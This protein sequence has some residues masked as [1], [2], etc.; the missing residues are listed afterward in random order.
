MIHRQF[1]TDDNRWTLNA[2]P[3]SIKILRSHDAFATLKW[4]FFMTH[5]VKDSD[6]IAVHRDRTRNPNVR[7]ECS[8]DTLGN[9][10][11]SVAWIAKQEHSAT[12]VYRRTKADHHVRVD[13][14]IVK[15]AIKIFTSRILIVDRLSLYALAVIPKRNWRRT[16]IRTE[17]VVTAATI[18]ADFCQ[19]THVPINR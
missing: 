11:L 17:R 1:T 13:Q 3:T 4:N 7:P 15:G 9:T 16:V 18:T 8:G 19:L 10:C 14:Q 2:N 12:T 5:R 6:D